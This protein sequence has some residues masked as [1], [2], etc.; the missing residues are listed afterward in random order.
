MLKL[1]KNKI[2]IWVVVIGLLFF[3]HYTSLLSPI[4][5][6]F[7]NAIKPL[8]KQAYQSNFLNYNKEQELEKFN[9]DELLLI[10]KQL[11]EENNSL[12]IE[13]SKQ[14]ELELENNQLKAFLD[15]FSNKEV[16]HI[17][18]NVIYKENIFGKTEFDESIFIDKGEKDDLRAGLVVLDNQGAVVGKITEV[19]DHISKVC[20]SINKDCKLAVALQNQNRTIG[21]SQGNLSLTLKINFISQ[22]D[23]VEEEDLVISSGLDSEIP[24]GF[25]V[26]KVIKVDKKSNEIWQDVSVEP[27]VNFNNLNIVSIIFP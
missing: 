18:A 13:K 25:I 4:E 19:K 10:A 27:L 17:I 26:G 24:R 15:F 14:Q 3:L 22:V 8:N 23:Q 9:K 11:K 6:L 1:Q 2:I 16:D 7:I 20:L 12:L 5:N 21:I